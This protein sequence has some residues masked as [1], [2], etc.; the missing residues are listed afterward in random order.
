MDLNHYFTNNE[1]IKSER[2]VIKYN[3]DSS[4]FEFI[5]D[6]GVFSKNKIDTGSI[7]LVNTYLKNKSPI[8]NFLDVGCGYGF[9]STLLCRRLKRQQNLT[10]RRKPRR[11]QSPRPHQRPQRL[12]SPLPAQRQGVPRLLS[13]PA[14][15]EIGRAHV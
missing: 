13:L 3:Y 15:R 10:P 5:S 1:N 4:C 11:R 7:N 2:R 6:N 8:K 14:G 9:I 12:L